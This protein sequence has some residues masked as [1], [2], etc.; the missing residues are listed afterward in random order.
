M[1]FGALKAIKS[2]GLSTPNEIGIMS[3]DNFPLAEYLDPPLSVIDIDTY[4]L[5]KQAASILFQ[6]IQKNVGDLQILI[7]TTLIERESTQRKKQ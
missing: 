4:S 6:K 5:G 3:F 1:A 2:N 7:A